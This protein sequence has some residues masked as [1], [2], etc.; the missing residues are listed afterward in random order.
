MKR[1]MPGPILA[2]AALLACA[3]VLS[4]AEAEKDFAT[5]FN[6]KDLTG[7]K[8]DARFWSVKDGA[9]TG[10]TTP[11]N[12]AP[13]NTFLIW[14]NGTLGDF[15]L[16]LSYKIVAN[17]DK[18][19]GDSGV[20]YRSKELPDY[21][22][23]GYQANLMVTKPLTGIL[24]E[25]KG[26]GIIHQLGQKVVI[27]TDPNDSNKHK[28]EVVGSFGQSEEIQ[29]SFKTNDWNDYVVIAQGNHLQHFINGKQTADVTDE[30]EARAAK[31]GILALQLHAGPP[32]M[33]QFKNI[34]MKTLSSEAGSAAEEMKKLQGV[35]EVSGGE[36]NGGP[37]APED[38]AGITLTIAGSTYTVV[39]GDSK[40]QGSFSI[41]T[42]KNPKQ[43]DVRPKT[44]SG[45][46]RTLLAI[47]E[48]GPE[49]FRVCYATEG[50]DRPR[51]FTTEVDSGRVVIA[52]KRKKQ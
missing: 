23:A 11:D 35:W 24:Y 16:R 8:G 41:D 6:R 1:I 7:W 9:I 30:D 15:E 10:Q 50:S 5:I 22:V 40:D 52:Y 36:V 42:T 33:V 51:A 45:A 49:G 44:G 39:K 12:P 43:M 2:C 14:T 21:V 38:T 34:R 3:N 27:K 26:R 20:Q 25:E 17:N 48:A 28:V 47:Y 37:M 29:A 19:F 46:G 18:S 4:A 32:M 31:A 13:H